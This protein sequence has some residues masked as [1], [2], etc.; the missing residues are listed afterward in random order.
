MSEASVIDQFA[1]AMISPARGTS[2]D[3]IAKAVREQTV[4]TTDDL[5]STSGSDLE[6]ALQIVP[7]IAVGAARGAT[8][9][10]APFGAVVSAVMTGAIGGTT[11]IG[12]DPVPAARRAAA[13]LIREAD[14]LGADIDLSVVGVVTGAAE[15]EGY[16]CTA[17]TESAI[18]GV[19][20]GAGQIGPEA[21]QTVEQALCRTNYPPQAPIRRVLAGRTKAPR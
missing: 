11:E 6:A 3:V 4:A 17:V 20:D 15:T 21:E 19:L 1:T 9:I 13:A 7:L 5:K 18:R 14:R 16:R 2:P 8:D 10:G 12:G